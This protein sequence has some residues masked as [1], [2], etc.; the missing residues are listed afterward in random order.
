V[1]P[2]ADQLALL[3]EAVLLERTGRLPEAEGAYERLL[4]R[5]PDLADSWYNLAVLQRRA[6]R[7]DAAL[8]SYQR[9]LECGVSR[10]EEVHLNRGVIYSDFLR[11]DAAAERELNAALALNPDYL[12]ALQNL[13]NLREDL[14]Q[15][16]AALALYERILALDPDSC[17]GLARYAELKSVASADDPL[18]AR[19]ARAIAQ[20]HRT[21]AE[22]ARLGFALGK[23]KDACGAYDSAFESYVAA[24][25]QSRACAG[26]GA[27]LYDRRRHEQFVDQLIG[28][29][30]QNPTAVAAPTPGA[31]PIFIC[32]MFRSG[33]TLTEQVLASHTR[34]AA[35]GEIDVLPSLV[36]N[37][38]APFPAKMSQMGPAQREQLARRYLAA[39]SRMFP[40][41]EHVTDKRPDNFLYIGLIKTLFPTARIV[42]TT[43]NAL[44]NCLSIY[45][46]HLDHSMGYALDLLDIAHYYRQYRR[47]M[48][49]WRSL[50]GDDIL[51]FDY[52]AFVREP[53]PAVEKLLAFCN[54]PW[55]EGCLSFHRAARAVKTASV[56]Q[57]REALYQR[58]SGRW[59]N[60][61]RQL[62]PL[63]AALSE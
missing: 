44:D 23:V 47:L 51:D 17:E 56:W 12:P 21:P 28:T 27:V 41:A 1:T 29:F 60:Y 58:S 33:S 48:A 10:P 50:Y 62:E 46:L 22:K 5:W 31:P 8:A 57:V 24:N 19:L 35:G 25:R 61:A 6:R 54:L 14:G 49:H 11:Q 15:R 53:R 18:V 43:R 4:A 40:G 20:P 37:E 7:F 63:R 42:H 38:L 34:V 32:G 26:P 52:D 3:H 2:G 59:R 16:D 36:Q 13:A 39:V 45:F 9:A 55:E 30:A